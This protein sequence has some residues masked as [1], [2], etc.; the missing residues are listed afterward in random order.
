MG[1]VDRVSTSEP[2]DPLPV[3]S[4]TV[5]PERAADHDAVR[6]LVG[7]AFGGPRVPDLVD[8]LRASDAWLGLSFVAETRDTDGPMVVGHVAYTRSLLDAPDRLR[9]VLVLSPLSVAPAWQRRGVG[10]RL[11]L[12]SLAVLADRAEPMVLLEGSPAYYGRL[13]FVPAEPLGL[14]RP[15][16]CIPPAAFQVRRLPAYDALG[17]RSIL[18]GTFVYHR[19]FWDH[20][21][22]GLRD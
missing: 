2:L 19:V 7:D 11:V 4:L 15:S 8:G 9:D 3:R 21:C 12:D 1:S 22:V 16:L 20:D 14:R 5:R 10:R 17:G 18:T 13:G 6:R